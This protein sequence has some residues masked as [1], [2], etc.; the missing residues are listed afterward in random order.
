LFFFDATDGPRVAASPS[1]G[2]HP[3]ADRVPDCI[4]LTAITGVREEAG[5]PV[6]LDGHN[7]LYT[8]INIGQVDRPHPRVGMLRGFE[9]VFRRAG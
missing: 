6:R 1:L 8:G 3:W 2:E 7:A 5:E 9:L 4:R